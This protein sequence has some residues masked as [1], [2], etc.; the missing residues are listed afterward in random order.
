MDWFY[1]FLDATA[2]VLGVKREA[3][4]SGG[5]GSA[6]ALRWLPGLTIAEKVCNVTIGWLIAMY[7]TEIVLKF[8]N[9]GVEK[10]VVAGVGFG[11]GL[12]GMALAAAVFRGIAET[13]L[14]EVVSSWFTRR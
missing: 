12:F 2:K 10:G 4:V 14:G 3:I 5:V 1:D 8:A 7:G 9:I 13:K 6:A 11:I